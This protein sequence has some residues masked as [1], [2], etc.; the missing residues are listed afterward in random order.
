MSLPDLLF[1]RKQLCKKDLKLAFVEAVFQSIS[2]DHPKEDEAICIAIQSQIPSLTLNQVGLCLDKLQGENSADI[3]NNDDVLLSIHPQRFKQKDCLASCLVMGKILQLA[4]HQIK[5]PVTYSVFE[6]Q[7]SLSFLSLASII[8]SINLLT[9][10][11]LIK[12]NMGTVSGSDSV[13]ILPN[14]KIGV[15]FSVPNIAKDSFVELIPITASNLTHSMVATII[16]RTHFARAWIEHQWEYFCRIQQ[17]RNHRYS[18]EQWERFFIDWCSKSFEKGHRIYSSWRPTSADSAKSEIEP[19]LQKFLDYGIEY[20]LICSD[21]NKVYELYLKFIAD[22]TLELNHPMC[23]KLQIKN[24]DAS[25]A[26]IIACLH[27]GCASSFSAEFMYRQT[28]KKC[29]DFLCKENNMPLNISA[30]VKLVWKE[31]ARRSVGNTERS[32]SEVIEFFQSSIQD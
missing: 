11:K 2:D 5:I 32:L 12:K 3:R 30:I 19:A 4:E 6:L 14:L 31:W 17:L 24:S 22:Y 9:V 28:Q 13:T 10:A 18:K 23:R 26:L 8:S 7:A 20:D 29:E 27:V 21:W 25:N 1:V 16:E 15:E